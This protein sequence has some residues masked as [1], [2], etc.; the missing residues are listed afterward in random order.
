MKKQYMIVSKLIL[1]HNVYMYKNIEIYSFF[2][3]YWSSLSYFTFT[4]TKDTAKNF[5]PKF[6]KNQP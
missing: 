4:L 2:A 5:W 6:S 1:I 3:F